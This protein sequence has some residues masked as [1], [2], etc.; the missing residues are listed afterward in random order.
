MWTRGHIP[1]GSVHLNYDKI[2]LTCKNLGIEY[3]AVVNG[4][5][6][7]QGRVIPVKNGVLILKDMRSTV[8]EAHEAMRVEREKRSG[9]SEFCF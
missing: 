1:S 5:E 9:W 7:K 2:E 4:F 3:V 6:R 8:E